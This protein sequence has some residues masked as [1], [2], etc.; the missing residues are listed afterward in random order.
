[1]ADQFAGTERREFVRLEYSV[2]VG[3]KVCKKETISK[4]LSGYT[5]DIS[6]AGLLCR[7]KE[8]VNKDD[9]LW[10]C[11]DRS[12]LEFCQELEKRVLIYQ[13][14][15][16]GKVARI[17]PKDDTFDIGVK[18]ITREESNSTFIYPKVHFLFKEL[19]GQG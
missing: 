13:N 2:P 14:G 11:F 1:M 17:E 10:L 5:S 7:V 12:T 8:K 6:Q 3:F 19:E 15:I 4:L 18:F 9:I 16:I